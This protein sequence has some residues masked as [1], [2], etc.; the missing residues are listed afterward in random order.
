MSAPRGPRLSALWILT[1]ATACAAA[2]AAAQFLDDARQS[3]GFSVAW[4][5]VNVIFG[6]F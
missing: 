5:A 4:F 3:I 1:L 2:P 6:V